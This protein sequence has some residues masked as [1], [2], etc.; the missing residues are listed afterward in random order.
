[1][2]G[3]SA[4]PTSDILVDLA[5][6]FYVAG[7]SQVEIARAL[8]LDASTVSRYLKRARDEGIVHVEIHR[9]RSLQGD[10]ALE[11]ATAFGLRKA[12][13]VAG[14]QGA[15]GNE[16]V[17]RA[18]AEYVNSQ[19]LNGMRLGLSWGRMLSAAIHRLPA[20][21]VSGLDVSMLHGGVGRGGPGIQ[22]HELARHLASLHP[23]SRVHYLHAPVLV[24]SP[25]IKAAM[26]RD[27][28]IR[29]ALESA[30]SS[31]VALVGIGT[32]DETA[33]LIRDHHI[34]PRDRK[35]LLD[36]GAVGDMSTRFFNASGEPV[37]MLD[38]RLISIEWDTLQDIPL[39]IGMAAGLE[40]R[41]AILGALR[42]G[43][44]DVLVTDESTARAVIK[45]G[46][47]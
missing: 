23:H 10:L 39:V 15:A 38:E 6:R 9:P 2:R 25:D 27:G 11:L 4:G 33:P 34:S 36:A 24:D 35:R 37:H 7:Q 43:M 22:G 31:Q 41:A 30:A 29:A 47:A 28:S 26:L 44:L 8:R 16:A 1:M 19:L 12:V 18:A 13:V 20:G 46:R 17:A 14:G 5:T 40:K 3:S 32:L 42:A 21:T 45:A